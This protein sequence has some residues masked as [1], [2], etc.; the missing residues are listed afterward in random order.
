MDRADSPGTLQ[1]RKTVFIRLSMSSARRQTPQMARAFAIV[2][3][4]RRHVT[5]DRPREYGFSFGPAR[6]AA[7]PEK[8][9]EGGM[10]PGAL[11]VAA[12]QVGDFR[13]PH[14]SPSCSAPAPSTGPV[15]RLCRV[16]GHSHATWGWS[17]VS[18][19][20]H[21]QQPVGRPRHVANRSGIP[22]AHRTA[23]RLGA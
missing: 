6:M 12:L 18:A 15:G 19:G 3:R 2:A 23:A 20:D 11:T 9:D 4:D 17:L 21:V 1:S 10:P 16:G 5:P 13:W 22:N 7:G 14:P 8:P